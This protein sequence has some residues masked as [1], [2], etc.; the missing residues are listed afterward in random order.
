M[1]AGGALLLLSVFAAKATSK[2]GV[3]ILLIFIVIGVL[4]GSEGIGGIPFDDSET[5]KILGTLSLI[6]IL[7]SGGLSSLPETVRPI[8]KEGVVLAT[9]GVFLSAAVMAIL[10]HFVLGWNFLE[11][12][13]LSAAISST[14]APAVFG[15]LRTQKIELIPK[16]RSL[17]EFESGSNDP[18]AVVLTVLLIQLIT[19]P[20]KLS[21]IEIL[22]DFFIQMSLGALAG[23]F[24]GKALVRLMNWLNL[25]F[26]GLYPVLTMAGVA[27]IYALTEFCGGNG[28]LSVFLAGFSMSGE[29]FVSKR[30]LVSFHDGLGWLIQV[31]M[32]LTL[33]IL[34]M[35]SNLGSVSYEGILVALGLIFIARPISV[36]FCLLP[37]K[38]K[39]LKEILFICWGGLRG[40]VPIILATY[41]VVA[42]VPMAST[43]FN[44]IFFVVIVSM[45]LQGLTITPVGKKLGVEFVTGPKLKTVFKLKTKSSELVEVEVDENSSLVGH[46]LEEIRSNNPVVLLLIHR[47]DHDFIPGRRT[48]I[49]A[50]DKLICLAEKGKKFEFRPLESQ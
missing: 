46:R 49:K 44:I 47:D 34:V 2:F 39:S 4:S 8:W 3:P 10:V 36:F 31:V 22:R 9:V 32:F 30:F 19:D 7:F 1:F 29:K 50:R 23:W 48:L 17:I 14:D 41:L 45:L 13:L 33:G 24:L 16:V 25:E 18:M 35:P 12:A 43:M 28:F 42:E 40:A 37:M 26:E 11:A 20:S 27:S 6:Y 21:W 15:I 5:T 38:Y